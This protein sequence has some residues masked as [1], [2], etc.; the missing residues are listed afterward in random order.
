MSKQNEQRSEAF[1]TC[2]KHRRTQFSHL[3]GT[4]LNLVFNKCF[5]G[6]VNVETHHFELVT[7]FQ[8]NV[9]HGTSYN[10]ALLNR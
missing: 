7:R 5:E 8:T 9:R 6:C 1:S 3:A 10:G 2:Q 4:L